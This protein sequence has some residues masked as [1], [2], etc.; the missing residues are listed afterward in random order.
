MIN[1][2]AIGLNGDFLLDA[3]LYDAVPFGFVLKK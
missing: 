3:R 1:R 2:I